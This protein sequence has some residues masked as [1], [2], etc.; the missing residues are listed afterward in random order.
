[1][2]GLAHSEFQSA[3]DDREPDVQLLHVRQSGDGTD[4]LVV[5]AVAG[6]DAEPVIASVDRG[7]PEPRELVK[8]PRAE[9]VGVASGVELDEDGLGLG[10]RAN[11]AQIRIDEEADFD[12]GVREGGNRAREPSTFRDDIESAFGGH[13]VAILGNDAHGVGANPASERDDFT[14]E[15]RLEVQARRDL[16]AQAAHVLVLDVST[17][18]AQV[19]RDPLR[20][21]LL[22]DERPADRIGDRFPT[23]LPQGR[24]VI[25]VDVESGHRGVEGVDLS[26]TEPG[27]YR[28]GKASG[29][30]A[31][32]R[33]IAGEHRG[34]KIAA[35][36]GQDTRP[37]LDRVREA[38]FSTLGERVPGAR[39]LDLYAGSGS[40]G[41]EALSRGAGS[42]RMIE[43]D[44]RAVAILKENVELLGMKDRAEVVRGDAL[45][46]DLWMPVLSETPSEPALDLV[47]LDPPYEKIEGGDTRSGILERATE[48]LQRFIRPGGCLVL[49]VPA[50]G[51]EGLVVPGPWRRD[52]RQY[53]S[54]GLLYLFKEGPVEAGGRP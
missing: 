25:D 2:D 24:D 30:L 50:R 13:L 5:E 35:P 10:G 39:V 22:R 21:G 36:P 27:P 49:H 1:V 28:A 14:L 18:L 37:M 44:S 7:G 52:V 45:R 15:A 41:L 9:R 11:L 3:R 12:A 54:S 32:M 29:T 48:L 19:A 6:V 17:V 8:L 42:A 20:A 34:R 46:R 53:G 31:P 43:K 51:V 4:V 40:L 38:M 26:R 47:F 33:I 16:G 23:G